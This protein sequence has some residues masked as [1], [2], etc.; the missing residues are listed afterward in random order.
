M[1]KVTSHTNVSVTFNALHVKFYP[2]VLVILWVKLCLCACP[3]NRMFYHDYPGCGIK[4]FFEHLL[5]SA[6][7][8]NILRFQLNTKHSLKLHILL[9]DRMV[10]T[11]QRRKQLQSTPQQFT[12]WR[13]EDSRR[14]PSH[15]FH[16]SMT[17]SCSF[18][19]LRD[20]KKLTGVAFV[21][22][23]RN[24]NLLN[25]ENVLAQLNLINTVKQLNS[26]TSWV[27]TFH[28]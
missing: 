3:V 16:T 23:E 11:S 25:A 21:L 7:F 22:L 27:Q 6:Y 20:S 28:S 26:E 13:A 4:E 19:H 17:L 10:H 9:F 2:S 8:Y 12:G 14:S 5:V 15:P 18:L 1:N 24:S